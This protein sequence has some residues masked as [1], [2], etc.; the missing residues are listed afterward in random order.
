MRGKFFDRHGWRGKD[1]H[2]MRRG[3]GLAFQLAAPHHDLPRFDVLE[4]KPRVP[5]PGRDRHRR[6]PGDSGVEKS[7]A[8]PLRRF[9]K[10][11]GRSVSL[12]FE[13]R[14]NDPTQFSSTPAGKALLHRGIEADR[15]N[16]RHSLVLEQGNMAWKMAQVRAATL[17]R[18]AATEDG[19]CGRAG[20]LGPIAGTTSSWPGFRP[21]VQRACSPAVAP[22]PTPKTASASPG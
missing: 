15:K 21:M 2:H 14:S 3:G 10:Q 13:F 8:R 16:N 6:H 5:I 1:R 9:S 11:E 7:E 4:V 12:T 22:V 19:C 18:S 20:D 17:R